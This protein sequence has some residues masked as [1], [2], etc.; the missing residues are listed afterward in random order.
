M[1]TSTIINKLAQNQSIFKSLL[2][3]KTE[4]EYLWRPQPTKWNLKE[5]VCHLLDEEILDFGFRTNHTLDTPFE[6]LPPI[7]P[8]GWVAKHD[9]ASKDYNETL[10][11]FLEARSKS[12]AWLKTQIDGHWDN[13][14]MHPELG[15]ITAKQFLNNW[16]AH[17]Y[18]HIRQINRYHYAHFKAHSDTSLD[19]AGNW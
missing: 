1:N 14:Y 9:Y 15:A 19:Y 7:D 4:P 18:L 8:E 13:T 11:K 12:I 17:D 5:I 10:N 6:P 3:G 2:E 16:L